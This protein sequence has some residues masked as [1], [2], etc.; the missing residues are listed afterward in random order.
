[1]FFI[2]NNN[3]FSYF[4]QTDYLNIYLTDINQICRD[5]RTLTVDERSEVIFFDPSRDVAMATNYLLT[6]SATFCS[7]RYISE[8]A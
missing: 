3:I 6:E 8:T 7:S 1:M 4:C 2:L 5:G